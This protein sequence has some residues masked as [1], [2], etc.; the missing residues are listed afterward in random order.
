M[1]QTDDTGHTPAQTC[2]L[3]A[4]LLQR[5]AQSAGGHGTP[6]RQVWY[7]ARMLLSTSV[8]E[9]LLLFFKS[10][11]T[12]VSGTLTVTIEAWTS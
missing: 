6:A 5:R 12:K 10:L 8:I 4:V 11:W 7:P 1:G 3:P 2:A 9:K